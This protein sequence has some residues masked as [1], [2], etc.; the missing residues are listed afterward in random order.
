MDDARVWAF[1]ESLWTGD[2]EHYRELVDPEVVMALPVRAAPAP[3]RR[4]RPGRAVD[5]AVGPGRDRPRADL[6]PAGGADRDRLPRH[7]DARDGDPYVAWCTSTYRRLGPEEWR[8]IQHSQ[9]PPLMAP[10]T[11]TET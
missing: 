5:P 10:A 1:E 2:A 11:Q 8:V 4:R 6:A 9:T 3:G 7:R